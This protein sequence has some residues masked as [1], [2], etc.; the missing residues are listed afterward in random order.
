MFIIDLLKS[1]SCLAQTS[2]YIPF[3]LI[4]EIF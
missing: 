1:D 2:Q 3:S 4:A